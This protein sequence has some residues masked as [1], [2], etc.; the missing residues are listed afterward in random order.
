MVPFGRHKGMRS[1]PSERRSKPSPEWNHYRIVA[2]DGVLRLA[3]NGKEVSGGA[4]CRWRK[5]YLGLESE[6]APTEWRNLRLR[7]LPGTGAA[8]D[9]TADEAQ[10]HRPLYNGLDLRGW[11]GDEAAKEAFR[12]DDWRLVLHEH[13]KAGASLVSE[14]EL[15]DF[16]LI[17]DV[18]LGKDGPRPAGNDLLPPG[19]IHFG[20]PEHHALALAFGEGS[21]LRPGAWARVLLRRQEGRFETEVDGRGVLRS[22]HDPLGGREKGRLRIVHPGA[23]VELANLYLRDLATPR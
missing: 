4:E 2:D 1:F 19:G 3:V 13:G 20:P 14:A 8:A 6:G 9:E 11:T 23:P 10:G 5:G 17:V 12:P 18:K 21:R 15:G 7:E 16:E 22:D